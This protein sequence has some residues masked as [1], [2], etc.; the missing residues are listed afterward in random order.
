MDGHG[1]DRKLWQNYLLNIFLRSKLH[2]VKRTKPHASGMI[3]EG[4]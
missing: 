1:A 3:K 2:L 4:Y